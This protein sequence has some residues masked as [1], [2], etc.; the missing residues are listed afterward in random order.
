[1]ILAY[2]DFFFGSWYKGLT[3][4]DFIHHNGVI[5]SLPVDKGKE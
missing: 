3:N 1:M 2:I 5:F 4:M